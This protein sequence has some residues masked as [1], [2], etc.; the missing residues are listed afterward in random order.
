M[1][2][3]MD[4]AS[5]RNCFAAAGLTASKATIPLCEIARLMERCWEAALE[6]GRRRSVGD[7]SERRKFGSEHQTDLNDLR[8]LPHSSHA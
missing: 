2:P 4:T 7:S 6:E 8:R 3:H 5:F 1:R